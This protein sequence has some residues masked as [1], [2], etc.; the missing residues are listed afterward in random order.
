[1]DVLGIIIIWFA[2]HEMNNAFG[3]GGRNSVQCDKRQASLQPTCSKP[4]S[5]VIGVEHYHNN[6]TRPLGPG[7]VEGKH[8]HW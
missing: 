2:A 5:M 3:K 6:R 4:I 1:M 8:T 7:H